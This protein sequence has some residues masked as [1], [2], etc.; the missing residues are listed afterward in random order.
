M[1]F[2]PRK[3]VE[4][5]CVSFT[6]GGGLSAR[7]GGPTSERF[8]T[9]SNAF[10][11]WFVPNILTIVFGSHGLSASLQLPE[12]GQQRCSLVRGDETAID[13]EAVQC[14]N[15]W[16]VG[17]W[18]KPSHAREEGDVVIQH[19]LE[20]RSRV[21]VEPLSLIINFELG[22]A[23][24][25]ARD[26]DLA[27]EQLIRRWSWTR[28]SLRRTTSSQP[29]TNKRGCIAKPLLNLRRRFR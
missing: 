14:E 17:R 20:R 11:N 15:R 7:Q 13:G 1:P 12:I 23:Y 26:Y 5:G 3:P 19:L 29:P 28:T 24:Y 9:R 25:F 22:L 2:L 6:S 8:L 16:Q 10:W 21:V 27:I 4:G 18:I